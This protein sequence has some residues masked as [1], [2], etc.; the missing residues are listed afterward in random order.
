MEERE[1]EEE[2]FTVNEK[3]IRSGPSLLDF[4]ADSNDKGNS[5]NVIIVVNTYCTLT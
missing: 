3:L 5:N 2:R 1:W 4:K